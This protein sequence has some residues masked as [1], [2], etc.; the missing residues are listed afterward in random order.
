MSARQQAE[1]KLGDR[2]RAIGRAAAA[3]DGYAESRGRVDI[4]VASCA[5]ALEI[6][7]HIGKRLEHSSRE[8]GSARGW[9]PRYSRPCSRSANAASDGALSYRTVTSPSSRGPSSSLAERQ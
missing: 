2:R 5:A 7:L 6:E 8:S 4:D 9:R 3:G 1:A